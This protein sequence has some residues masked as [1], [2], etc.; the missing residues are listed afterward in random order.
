M[1]TQSC[2]LYLQNK[3]RIQPFSPS[4]ARSL[5]QVTITPRESPY[6][7]PP[8]VSSLPRVLSPR[9]GPRGSLLELR[10]ALITPLL[11]ACSDSISPEGHMAVF[12]LGMFSPQLPG[13]PPCLLHTGELQSGPCKACPDTA[14]AW[15]APSPPAAAPHSRPLLFAITPISLTSLISLFIYST[16]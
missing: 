6:Q 7:R 3:P 16:S 10:S 12:L 13:S 5:A 9:S 11:R 15:P 1:H 8:P 14:C 2:Q 4:M